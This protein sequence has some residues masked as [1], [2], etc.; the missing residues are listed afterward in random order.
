M[1]EERI[2]KR[3]KV[4]VYLLDKLFCVRKIY[5]PTDSSKV[6]TSAHQEVLTS[7]ICL[8]VYFSD[9]FTI[10]FIDIISEIVVF[11]LDK[12]R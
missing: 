10:S 9:F 1:K 2:G 7:L 4:L 3:E 12:K 5:Q 6:C 8:F 11:N